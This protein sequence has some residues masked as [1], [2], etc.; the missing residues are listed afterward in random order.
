MA[1][2]GNPFSPRI[3][4][5]R[6]RISNQRDHPPQKQIDFLKLRK[7]LQY[8]RREQS[9]IGMVEYTFDTHPLHHLIKVFCGKAFEKCVRITVIT[10]TIDHFVSLLIQLNHLIHRIYIILSVT[11]NGN[12]NITAIL[13]FHQSG[14]HRILVP[15]VAALADSGKMFIPRR[16]SANNLPGIIPAAIIDKKYSA[17]LQN[18]IRLNQ[19]FQLV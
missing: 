15:V 4:R 14:K 17:V 11:V 6:T 3:I 7:G 18:L 1:F 12:G 2:S 13:R 9:V 16:Q 8:F 19:L 10:Y 5:S